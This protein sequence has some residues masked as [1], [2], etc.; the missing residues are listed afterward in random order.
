MSLLDNTVDVA[1][2]KI[3]VV[4]LVGGAGVVGVLVVLQAR[5]RGRS[6]ASTGDAAAPVANPLTALYG[7]SM[8]GDLASLQSQLQ[9]DL[10]LPLQN[11]QQQLDAMRST[12]GT[13]ANP[14]IIISER[15]RP[16][17]G[18][19]GLRMSAGEQA[20]LASATAADGGV[21]VYGGPSMLAGIVG[22]LAPNSEVGI[23]PTAVSGGYSHKVTNDWFR[24]ADGGWVSAFDLAKRGTLQAPAAPL[25]TST[26]SDHAAVATA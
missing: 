25:S 6:V 3:P 17:T 1:G 15:V 7:A 23:F 10:Q 12:S 4:A 9:A 5:A 14:S 18:P 22:R 19:L 16:T 26:S 2:K 11:F 24:T 8:Q 13:P 21:P 20:W